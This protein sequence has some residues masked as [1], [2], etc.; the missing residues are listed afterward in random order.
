MK[1]NCLL[2]FMLIAISIS[3]SAQI[4]GI[5]DF[6]GKYKFKADVEFTAAG[7]GYKNVLKSES[8][9]ARRSCR[10]NQVRLADDGR[11]SVDFYGKQ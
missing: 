9:V 3:V 4:T 8:D 11:E 1:K 10:S 6:Y 2:L 7:N 5:T